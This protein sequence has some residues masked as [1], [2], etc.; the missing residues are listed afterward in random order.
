M[1]A[2]RGAVPLVA[3][4]LALG[5]PVAQLDTDV[6][7]ASLVAAVIGSGVAWLW[8]GIALRA[9]PANTVALGSF[10]IPV[11]AALSAWVQFRTPPPP[12]TAIGLAI[13]VAGLAGSV[14]SATTTAAVPSAEAA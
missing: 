5:H 10:A 1:A 9:L 8:W 4:A 11:I 3:L 14:L 6:I 2:A 12:L 7:V 13:V